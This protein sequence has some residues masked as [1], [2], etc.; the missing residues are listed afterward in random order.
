[1]NFK[2]LFR[3]YF[4]V[5]LKPP[6]PVKVRFK[7]KDMLFYVRFVKP[8]WKPALAGFLLMLVSTGISSI[9]PLGGK[10]LIDNVL[11]K[12]DAADILSILS[13]LG[14]QGLKPLVERILGS[15]NL[16]IVTGLIFG[17]LMGVMSILQNVANF[18]FNTGVTFKVQT[19]LFDRVLRYP[20]SIFKEK[21][22]GYLMARL[23]GDV[24]AVQSFFSQYILQFARTLLTPL[25]S[26]FIL[27]HLNRRMTFLVLAI[28]PVNVLI[29]YLVMV[30]ARSL[31][32]RQMEK[33]ADI[34]GDIQQALAGIEVIKSYG[35]EDREKTKVSGKMQEVIALQLQGLLLSSFAGYALQALNL[36]SRLLITWLCGREVLR[37]TMSIGDLTSFTLYSL[38]LTGQFGGIFNQVLSLQYLFLSMGRLHEM[39]AIAPESSG[40]K[41]SGPLL[42]PADVRG[43]LQFRNVDFAY[44]DGPPVLK[45]VSLDVAPGEKIAVMGASGI[46]KTTLI[47][48]VLKFYLPRRGKILLDGRDLRQ[49]DTEW[50][51]SRTAVV[52]QETFLFNDTLENNIKYGRPDAGSAEVEEAARKAQIH[53]DIIRMEKGYQTPVGERGA[54]LSIGQK[55]RISLARAFLKNPAVLILDEP[56]SALDRRTEKSLGEALRLITRGRTTILITHRLPLL[57]I[58]DRVFEFR[59][60][61]LVEVKRK[62]QSRRSISR[63]KDPVKLN[64]S[65]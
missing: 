5:M 51:R 20:L 50:L 30:R 52:S 35:A 18:R 16:V 21:Q 53:E 57:D 32:Y 48:L 64:S 26:F 39:F 27:F 44:Q 17:L 19:E 49:V 9:S 33:N 42:R 43:R 45:N 23:T 11:Q 46:G 28:I 13:S 1:M 61:G 10:V 60:E 8:F 55:Q 6:D 4:L 62:S 2:K 22:T 24:S 40:P 15:L 12:K 65:R 58:A 31:S 63:Q 54:R 37:G 25:F 59:A 34:S 7:L 41:T 3:S 14:L 38:Q 29:N 47:S 36:G 56:T